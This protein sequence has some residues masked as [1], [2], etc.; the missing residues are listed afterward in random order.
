MLARKLLGA[1]GLVGGGGPTLTYLGNDIVANNGATSWTSSSFTASE[2]GLFIAAALVVNGSAR[3]WT[4]LDIGGVSATTAVD[5]ATVLGGNQRT[6]ARIGTRV[7]SSGSYTVTITFSSNIRTMAVAAYLLTG[8]TSATAH[9]SDADGGGTTVTSRS[10]TLDIPANGVGI[11]VGGTQQDSGG[12]TFSTSTG[13][14]TEDIDWTGS[15]Y[16][17]EYG[18]AA[19]NIQSASAL[20]GETVTLS[21]ASNDETC[22]AGASWS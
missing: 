20:T 16:N 13:S 7:V 19:G 4:G 14:I 3:S 22:L 9:D 17:G 8:Y 2:S 18:G 10:V 12:Y 6:Q 5:V 1:G 21:F 15:G 11:F